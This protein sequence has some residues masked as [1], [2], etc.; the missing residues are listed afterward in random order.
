MKCE[1]VVDVAGDGGTGLGAVDAI[2][3]RRSGRVDY[4]AGGPA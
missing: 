3:A 1:D 2:V 4:G